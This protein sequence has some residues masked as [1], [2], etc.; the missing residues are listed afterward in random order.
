MPAAIRPDDH[1]ARFVSLA[2]K[3][4]LPSEQGHLGHS[5]SQ[6][7]SYL[8]EK[9]GELALEL[10]PQVQ[11]AVDG[12][13]IL[14]KLIQ[15]KFNISDLDVLPAMAATTSQALADTTAH[16]EKLLTVPMDSLV[17]YPMVREMFRYLVLSQISN[18]EILD[19][20]AKWLAP[21]FVDH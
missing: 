17:D 14:A 18:P 5:F 20:L 6:C 3:K 4:R 9:A 19:Y 15:L 21:R 11:L 7:S 2:I 12:G 13:E 16:I 1:Y 10:D 8:F